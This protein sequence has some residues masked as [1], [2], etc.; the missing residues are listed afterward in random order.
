M[1]TWKITI[2]SLSATAICACGHRNL[3]AQSQTKSTTIESPD[4]EIHRFANQIENIVGNFC[5]TAFSS[6]LSPSGIRAC[7]KVT[8][9][10]TVPATEVPRAMRELVGPTTDQNSNAPA[11][12]PIPILRDEVSQSRGIPLEIRVQV[13]AAIASAFMTGKRYLSIVA[14]PGAK[15]YVGT[16]RSKV[17]VIGEI[18]SQGRSDCH[19][20]A[21]YFLPEDLPADRNCRVTNSES[22]VTECRIG[23]SCTEPNRVP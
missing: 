5:D 11:S 20:D 15:L 8:A 13:G 10:L 14:N 22:G 9:F 19:T 4:T 16:G 23:V 17:Y 12:A 6:E 2:A 1:R 7:E 3:P 18:S 21:I